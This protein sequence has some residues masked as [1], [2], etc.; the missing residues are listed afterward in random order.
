MADADVQYPKQQQPNQ[1]QPHDQAPEPVDVD[2][3]PEIAG[4]GDAEQEVI[5]VLFWSYENRCIHTITWPCK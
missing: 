3:Q 2:P 4:N 1:Q 5:R